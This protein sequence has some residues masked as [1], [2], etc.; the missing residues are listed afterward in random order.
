MDLYEHG[1]EKYGAEDVL[2]S[3]V[4]CDWT[5]IAAELRHHPAAELP[6]FALKQ[7]EIGVAT[8]CHPY[9][10]VSRCG[11]GEAQSTRV[12]R[13]TIWTCPSGVYEEKIHLSEWHE[14]LHIYLPASR[15][16][17][18]SEVKSGASVEAHQI[19]YLSDL[20]D[21]LIRQIAFTILDEL[22]QPSSAGRVLV[23][24]LGMSLVARLVQ[25]CTPEA[26][27][28]LRSL[29]VAHALDDARFK[30]VINFIDQ[31]IEEDLSVNDLSSVAC[32]SP[33]HFIRLFKNRTGLP[34]SRYLSNRR[35]TRAK[36]L[37]AAGERI[38]D[39]AMK[40]CFSS[41][42]SFTRAFTK[43]TGV[44]PANFRRQL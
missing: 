9:A 36:E 14:C 8:R 12:A 19:L 42:A 16:I 28:Q 37:L 10:V 27:N 26:A 21:P 18:L 13:G 23:E 33:F 30:R 31:N 1:L 25:T 15:F 39:I 34:P 2:A 40:C 32:L 41:Q 4:S 44:T 29:H 11:N 5:G 7:T 3:A 6:G 24:T 38:A 17:E 20:P 22:Q 43:A 35:L